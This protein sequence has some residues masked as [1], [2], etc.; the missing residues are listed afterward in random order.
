M[1]KIGT[2][3]LKPFKD[4]KTGSETIGNATDGAHRD[5]F[6]DKQMITKVS[7][8][9]TKLEPFKMGPSGP[10]KNTNPD[11]PPFKEGGPKIKTFPAFSD[12]R[13]EY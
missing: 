12:K 2:G 3:E 6:F 9:V 11:H 10:G 13:C 4:S 1:A 7:R 5:G 8:N